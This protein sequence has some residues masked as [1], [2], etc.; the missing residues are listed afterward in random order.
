MIPKVIHYC[1]LSGEPFPDSIKSYVDGWKRFFPDYQFMLWTKDSFDVDSVPFVSQAVSVRKWAFAADYIRL[2]ALYNYGGIYLDSDV[3]IVRSFDS[4]LDYGF[5]TSMEYHHHDALKLG[6][7]DLINPDGTS[8]EKHTPK[9]GICLQ[10]AIMGAEPGHP[11]LKQCLDYYKDRD[12]ILPDGSFYNKVILPDILAMNA[13][14]F[15]LRYLDAEQLLSSDMHIFPSYYFAGCEG[16]I[17]DGCYA[18]H[19]CAGSWREQDNSFRG[20][21]IRKTRSLLKKMIFRGKKSS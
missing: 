5:F 11:F 7:F 12:F 9:P 15:G 2:Y 19:H 1:W 6:T 21:V 13:E 8:K 16:E 17:K 14:D 3:E 4:F 10:A 18:I 20:R